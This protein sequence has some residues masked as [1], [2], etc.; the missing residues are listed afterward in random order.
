MSYIN[1]EK[2]KVSFPAYILRYIYWVNL[3]TFFLVMVGSY[4]FILKPLYISVE[5]K[6]K[7]LGAKSEN[8]KQR[9]INFN[10]FSK[11]KEE[12]PDFPSKVA[13]L[14]KIAASE[15][16]PGQ[17][18]AQIDKIA[19]DSNMTL[20]SITPDLTGSKI[21]ATVVL[22]GSYDNFMNFLENIENNQ[23]I[24]NVSGLSVTGSTNSMVFSIKI[25]T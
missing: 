18:L 25:K 6:E 13:L 3:L 22:G 17:F 7:E 11:L 2:N 10:Q 19:K 9:E 23:L 16:D 14:D 1:K 24:M 12:F 15:D 20:T 4:L 5:K 21:S 8:L